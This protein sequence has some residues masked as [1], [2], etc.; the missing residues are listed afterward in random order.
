MMRYK[1]KI[2]NIINGTRLIITALME[3]E[4]KSEIQNAVGESGK[5]NNLMIDELLSRDKKRKG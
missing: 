3:L 2:A 4:S 5:L 1:N